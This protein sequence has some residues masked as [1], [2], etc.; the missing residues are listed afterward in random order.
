MIKDSMEDFCAVFFCAYPDTVIISAYE[1]TLQKA[2]LH[3]VRLFDF[4]NYFFI[5]ASFNHESEAR[6]G[7]I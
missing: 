1:K 4:C 3:V 2:G 6:S 5:K 7:L